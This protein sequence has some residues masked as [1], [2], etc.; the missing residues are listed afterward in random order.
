MNAIFSRRSVRQFLDKEIEQEKIVQILKAAM[1]APSAYNQ[2]AWEFVV[3]S[4]RENLEK[5]K[6][7]SPYTMPLNTATLAVVVVCP[8]DTLKVPGMWEQDLGAATQNLM[9]EACDIGLGSVWLGVAPEQDRIEFLQKL[10]DLPENKVPYAVVALGYPT[11]QDAN[12]F[13]DR[14]DETKIT[15]VK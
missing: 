4:G 9:L 7:F 1:Q 3:V 15:Y 2:Q 11:Q 14:Y 5:L 6:K 10:Y 13:V 12:K 8:K